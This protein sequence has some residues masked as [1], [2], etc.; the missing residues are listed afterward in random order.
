MCLGAFGSM[1]PI[2]S[3]AG[4]YKGHSRSGGTGPK[5]FVRSQHS[6]NIWLAHLLIQG[7]PPY[8]TQ[9]PFML[10]LS[11]MVPFNNLK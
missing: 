11:C 7:F 4:K 1:G 9:H 5:P 6:S 2:V 8:L 10:Q 3:V